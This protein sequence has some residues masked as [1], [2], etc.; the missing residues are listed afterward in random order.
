MLNLIQLY[1]YMC[2]VEGL[3]MNLLTSQVEDVI[4]CSR[5]G[6]NRL[7][8][9]LKFLKGMFILASAMQSEAKVVV[10]AA[11]IQIFTLANTQYPEPYRTKVD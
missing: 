5:S 7:Q 6:H 3:K 1:Y 4:R 11:F 9:W 2:V 10:A 8:W